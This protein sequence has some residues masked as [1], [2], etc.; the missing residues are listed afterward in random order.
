[1][2]IAAM[3]PPIAGHIGCIAAEVDAATA[4]QHDKAGKYPQM[5]II[6]A[7]RRDRPAFDDKNGSDREA[8]RQTAKLM[9][10][11]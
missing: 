9:T 10:H 5:L 3:S 1:L 7:I 11:R 6:F 4:W 2:A 8:L